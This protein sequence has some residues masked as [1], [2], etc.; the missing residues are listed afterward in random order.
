MIITKS[1][2]EFVPNVYFLILIANLRT[3]YGFSSWGYKLAFNSQLNGKFFLKYFCLF[4]GEH[5]LIL[6]IC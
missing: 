2:N 4:G 1:I 3:L 5:I 6:L